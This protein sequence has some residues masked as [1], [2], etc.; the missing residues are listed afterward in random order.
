VLAWLIAMPTPLGADIVNT[1]SVTFTGSQGAALSALSNTVTVAVQTTTAPLPVPDLSGLDGKTYMLT[2]EIAFT[3]PVNG[4]TF[5]WVFALNSSSPAAS[6]RGSM[7]S[8]PVAAGNDGLRASAPSAT[9]SAPRA[10]AASFS[11]GPGHYLLTITVIQGSQSQSASARITLV[12]ATLSD[13]R[14]YPNPW[15]Q[16]KHAVRPITFAGLTTGTTIKIFTLSGRKITEIKT[17]GPTV[18]WPLTN[19][20]GDK[21]A[22]GVYLY[23]VT[24]TAGDKMKGKIGI[25]K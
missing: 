15:R 20:Q 24:D 7:D 14:V 9:T 13:V 25:I 12:G 2:D 17:D 3:Y 23:V 18:D 4:V 5:E 11:I 19:D 16:D 21:V 8:P 6:G 10:T 22:S 1:A